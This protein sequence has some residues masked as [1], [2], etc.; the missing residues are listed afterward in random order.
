MTNSK[1]TSCS[2][3]SKSALFGLLIVAVGAL[4]LAINLGWLDSELRQVV[5]SWQMIFVVFAIIALVRRKYLQMLFWTALGTFFLLPRI[6]RVY[7]EALP[8]IDGNFASNYW[9]VLVILVGIG[10]ILNIFFGKKRFFLFGLGT[11]TFSENGDFENVKFNKVE[12]TNGTYVREVIFG[13]HNDIFLEPVFRGG[14]IET[15]FG[16]VELDLRK[17]T[18]PEGDTLLE[19]ES[20]FG[21]VILHLPDDWVVVPKFEAIFGGVENK[22]PQVVQVDHSRRLIVTGEVIFGGCQI[23]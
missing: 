18:L 10:V 15:V 21:G 7:P 13:G 6:A 11:S 5:F 19:I 3:K 9:P 14:K 20:V 16:G 12:G 2:R 8:A 1:F 22:R 4:F 17:T 23:R